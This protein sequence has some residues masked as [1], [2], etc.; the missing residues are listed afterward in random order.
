MEISGD[1]LAAVASDLALENAILRRRNRQLTT[2]LISLQSFVNGQGRPGTEPGPYG[3]P[4]PGGPRSESAGPE[5]A[6]ASG[7]PG[8]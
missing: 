2:E 5:A 1:E 3:P 4:L 7:R 8:A 6:S